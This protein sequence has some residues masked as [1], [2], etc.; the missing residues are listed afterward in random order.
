MEIKWFLEKTPSLPSISLK[1]AVGAQGPGPE[2]VGKGAS[3]PGPA[4]RD[5]ETI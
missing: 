1:E 3:E 4:E 5:R 2:P